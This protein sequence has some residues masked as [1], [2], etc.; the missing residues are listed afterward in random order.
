MIVFISGCCLTA[1][2][3]NCALPACKTNADL[4]DLLTFY[5]NDTCVTDNLIKVLRCGQGKLIELMP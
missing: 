5:Q 1:G 3:D 2:V 4:L